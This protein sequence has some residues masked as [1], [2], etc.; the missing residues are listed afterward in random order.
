MSAFA[1]RKVKTGT[2]RSVDGMSI[3]RDE[4]GQILDP[5]FCCNTCFG[6]FSPN[7]CANST[8]FDTGVRVTM[9]RTELKLCRNMCGSH[10]ICI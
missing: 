9:N 7:L 1:V 4:N 2:L 8:L 3:S 5:Y 10:G 6:S